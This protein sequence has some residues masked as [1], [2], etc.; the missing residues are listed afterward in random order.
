MT[1]LTETLP[2]LLL[3]ARENSL[4]YVRP[5]LHHHGLTEPQW[6][7]LHILCEHPNLTAQSLAEHSCVLSP[8]LSRILNRFAADGLILRSVSSADQRAIN[9]RLSAKGRRLC[10][11]LRP[12]LALQYRA[13]EERS[14]QEELEQLAR[15]LKEFIAV[16]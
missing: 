4:A 3:K 5:V 13:L 8:S 2:V 11:R 15:L 7:V 16:P 6:R 14:G 10:A 9:I 12:K 1:A